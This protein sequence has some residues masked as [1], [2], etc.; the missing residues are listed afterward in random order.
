MRLNFGRTDYKIWV[1][2]FVESVE[3]SNINGNI[4]AKNLGAYSE[5]ED[6]INNG[7]DDDPFCDEVEGRQ[8]CPLPP[9][10]LFSI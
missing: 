4:Y 10:S 6:D 2:V 8:T 1:E 9:H 7:N 5:D 3:Q